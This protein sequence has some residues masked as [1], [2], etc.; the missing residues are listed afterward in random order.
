MSDDKKR[1]TQEQL[2]TA[3]LEGGHLI[4]G[5]LVVN[6]RRCGKPNCRCA[7]GERH[8]SLAIT[9]KHGG[10]SVLLHVPADLQTEATQAIRDYQR[11]KQLLSRLSEINLAAFRQNV[12]VA[13]AAK[14]QGKER[15]SCSPHRL[16][17]PRRA[18]AQPPL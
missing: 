9:Y 4:K 11:V 12:Q 13:R 15:R 16:E 6:R 18:A 8:E 14:T 1:D 17:V 10:R 2:R 7:E 3:L 5:S